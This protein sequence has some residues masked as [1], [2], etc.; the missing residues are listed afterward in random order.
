[1][2]LKGFFTP[3]ISVD[4]G[5]ANS[6]VYVKNR[7]IVVCEPSV[8]AIEKG[9]THV[10]AVG[11]DAQKMLERAPDNIIAIRPL[12]SGVIADF[13][14][15]EAMFSYFIRKSCPHRLWSKFFKPRVVIAVPSDITE[16][17]KRALEEAAH[18]AGAG[19]VFLIEDRMAAAIGAG[20]PVSEREGCMIVDVGACMM[21]AAIISLA[22]IVHSSS[23][24]AAGDAMD[25][26]IMDYMKNAHNLLVEER[27]AE[28]I[29]IEIGSAF[30][31][32]EEKTMEVCGRDA[33]TGLLKTITVT[34]EEIRDA[35]K[36]VLSTIVEAVRTTLDCCEPELAADLVDRGIVLS[37][38]GAQLRGLD[39]LLSQQ[40]GLS[41]R[42]AEDPLSTVVI[43]TGV[44]ADELD[45]LV[46]NRQS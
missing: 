36:E 13:D 3:D 27:I 1:M 7:G 37:G 33:V 39:Q 40:T 43:G 19:E 21:N 30:P 22:N 41:V 18:S 44:V 9:A 15:T 34:S 26:A 11:E 23:T 16:V 6:V 4:L 25:N 8:V 12:K 45:F 10:L 5:S 29:K 17:E 46:K 2:N 32:D 28:K 38:G 14:I 31:I 24:F 20:L 42:I 35:L